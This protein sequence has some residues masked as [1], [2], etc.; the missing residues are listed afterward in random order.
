MKIEIAYAL[1]MIQHIEVL[2]LPEGSTVETAL[3]TMRELPAL[4]PKMVVD[5]TAVGL[6]GKRVPVH[7]ALKEGDRVE[8]Y[9]PLIVDPKEA[10]RNRV[11]ASDRSED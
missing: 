3:S 4:F 11:K 1:P 5:P 6:F 8:I 2:E 10:R 7:T 9:R